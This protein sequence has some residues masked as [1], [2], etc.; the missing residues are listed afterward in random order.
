MSDILRVVARRGPP[1]EATAVGH[2]GSR[3]L[4]AVQGD[5]A[6]QGLMV[7]GQW[8]AADFE[9]KGRAPAL[10]WTT[11]FDAGCWVGTVSIVVRLADRDLPLATEVLPDGAIFP[12]GRTA[13]ERLVRH[14]VDAH[15]HLPWGATGGAR[16][17]DLDG[18][19]A[20]AP[21]PPRLHIAALDV[22]LPRLLT[23]L[24]RIERQP[25]RMLRPGRGSRHIE[26][27]GQVDTRTL[28]ALAR[29]PAV[30]AAIRR[31]PAPGGHPRLDVPVA[32]STLDHPANRA[33]L[34]ALK[35]LLRR[36]DESRAAFDAFIESRKGTPGV[37]AQ[38]AEVARRTARLAWARGEI[39]R[40]ARRPI[41]RGVQPAHPTPG[42]EQ[43]FADDP[44]YGEAMRIIR[45]LQRPAVRPAI[46]GLVDAHLRPAYDLWE[47]YVWCRV[48]RVVRAALGPGWRWT[49]PRFAATGLCVGPAEDAFA[50]ARRDGWTVRVGNQIEFIAA[51]A[52]REAG[53]DWSD[54][55]FSLHCKRRPDVTV[56][57]TSP[58][59]VIRWLV[60]DAKFTASKHTVETDHLPVTH[61]YRDG[62][63]LGGRRPDG[64][65]LV[66]PALDAA[67]QCY[68]APAY[69]DAFDVGVFVDRGLT[70]PA[71]HDAPADDYA[72]LVQ[73]LRSRPPASP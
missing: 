60:L 58:E 28:T 17:G 51:S 12:D 37:K 72:R 19:D 56:E 33:L 45:R 50:E 40:A 13:I 43:V 68:A 42:A 53:G 62:L 32:R 48:V 61:H 54:G 8:Q 22:W 21:P 18:A 55:R 35:G 38:R 15:A 39:E 69:H 2:C 66:L 3:I 36:V 31:A 26:H 65:F 57:I 9:K 46:A 71:G 30:A 1:F 34:H 49:P 10:W 70:C 25:L 64:V 47:Q 67:A 7:D 59:G 29:Q 4:L 24:G 16:S 52:H 20:D 23:A 11:A 44:L 63:R 14:L 41:W 5:A 6:P 27:V 73:W